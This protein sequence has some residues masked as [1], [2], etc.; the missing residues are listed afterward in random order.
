M[1]VGPTQAGKSTMVNLLLG[2]R[3]ADVSATAGYTV[4][5]QGFSLE[6]TDK[7]WLKAFFTEGQ[8]VDQQALQRDRL[9]EYSCTDVGGSVAEPKKNALSNTVLWDTPDFDSVAHDSYFNPVLQCVALAD[10]VLMVVSKEKYADKSVW[11]MLN[12][13][14]LARKDV[15]LVINKAPEGIRK[16]L[17]ESVQKKFQSIEAVAP[18]FTA[19]V[20]FVDESD[21][22]LDELTDS[23]D[24]AAL[25][26]ALQQTLRRN[27]AGVQQQHLRAFV[28]AHWLQWTN[29]I[30]RQHSNQQAWHQI[31]EHACESLLQTYE[32]EYLDNKRQDET[33]QLAVAELLVLL[34]IPGLAEPLTRIRKVVTWPVRK[35]LSS[36]ARFESTVKKKDSRSEEERLLESLYEHCIT[37]VASQISSQ[38]QAQVSDQQ[39]WQ[40]LQEDL[41]HARPRLK[42]GWK[43]ESENYRIL[44]KVQT[45][46]AA[47]SLYEKLEEQPATLNGLRAARVTGDAAAVVLAVKSGGLGAADLVIAPAVLS[48]TTMLTEGALGQYMNKVQGDLKHYQ[49]KSVSAMV[50]RKL[51][52]KLQSLA[53]ASTPSVTPQA[54]AALHQHYQLTTVAD[55]K[56]PENRH[57]TR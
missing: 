3:G 29:I 39:W 40:A 45:E 35:M 18:E 5:C 56:E 11:D 42:Q 12:T 10:L 22:P 20:Y 31:V 7:Q 6:N 21:D 1:A 50:N 36:A 33:L 9:N 48:L 34:E 16:A 2:L 30:T 4:H 49:K 32:K 43:N 24:L 27:D 46:S 52:I 26:S 23:K 37:G 41:L 44:L 38:Q 15:V 57:D 53:G 17:T 55:H 51:K 25:R 47:R 14:A 8:L 54:L 28:D 19:A 13:L